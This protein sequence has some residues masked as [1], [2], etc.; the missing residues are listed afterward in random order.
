VLH[1]GYPDQLHD[2]VL[3]IIDTRSGALLARQ[4]F[5]G[6][7]YLTSNGTVYRRSF[8]DTGEV[9]IETF[10]IEVKQDARD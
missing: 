7:L 6:L 4:R 8:R 9:Y 10:A 5:P 1:P 2:T 3:D